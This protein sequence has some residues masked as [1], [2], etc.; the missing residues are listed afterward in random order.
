MPILDFKTG[1]IEDFRSKPTAPKAQQLFADYGTD[2]PDDVIRFL[3]EVCRKLAEDHRIKYPGRKDADLLMSCYNA[4]ENLGCDPNA[5]FTEA[6]EEL[7]IQVDSMRRKY[8]RAF[9]KK[10]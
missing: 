4:I 3:R 8:D 7:D 6:A 5:I 2:L 9:P 10:K 1:S